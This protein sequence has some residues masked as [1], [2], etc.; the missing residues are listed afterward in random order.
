MPPSKTTTRSRVAWRKSRIGPTNLTKVVSRFSGPYPVGVRRA[1]I[2]LLALA[3][4]APGAASAAVLP[5]GTARIAGGD[6]QAGAV[7]ERIRV[8]V[9]LDSDPGG[10]AL[11]VTLPALVDRVGG[12]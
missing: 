3:L 12:P 10:A 6:L 4:A 9:E 8:A 7:G 11:Q 1:P 5:A 2:L